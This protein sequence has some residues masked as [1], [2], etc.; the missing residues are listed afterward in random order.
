MKK[1]IIVLCPVLLFMWLFLGV[2]VG[3][4]NAAIILLVSIGASA[5]FICWV[6][7][8]DKHVDDD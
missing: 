4:M 5:L 7:F 2:S 6:D 3:F 1:V 8:V